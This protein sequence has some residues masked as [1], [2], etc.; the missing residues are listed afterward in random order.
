MATAKFPHKIK[1]GD[2]IGLVA[3]SSFISSERLDSCI[4]VIGDMGY[5][6]K[7]ADNIT[8]SKGGYMAGE[9]QIRADWLNRMFEDKTVDAIFCVRGGDGSNRMISKVN[10]DAVKNNPKI[11][12]GYSDITQLLNLFSDKCG[13]VTFHGP[14]VSSNMVDDFDEETRTAFMNAINADGVYRYNEPSGKPIKIIQEGCGQVSGQIVGGNLEL[15][16]TSIGTPYE[17]DTEGKILFIEE[18]GDHIGN[19]DRNLFQLRDC[20]KLDKVAGIMIGQFTD[21]RIDM[22]GVYDIEN[23]VQEALLSSNR[24]D[25]A[26]VPVLTGIQSGHGKP[27]ITIPIGAMCRISVPDRLIEFDVER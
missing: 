4:K 14:M 15:I 1:Q 19:T 17:V 25:A 5:E 7:V 13:L 9:E 23:I 22:P 16:C 6:V 8:T 24:A 12:V 20:G 26:D 11:F 21:F 3:C 10:L 27:M 2:C 18:I